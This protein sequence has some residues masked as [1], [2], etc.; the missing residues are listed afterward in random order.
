MLIVRDE[1]P[2]FDVPPFSKDRAENRSR[3]PSLRSWPVR[4][5]IF[6]AP[7]RTNRQSDALM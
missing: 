6:L 5:M 1:C 2:H 4:R 3:K 7:V